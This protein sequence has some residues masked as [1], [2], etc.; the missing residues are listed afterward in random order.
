MTTLQTINASASPEV[1]INENTIA[2]SPAGLFG[3]KATTTA[4]LT[5]GYYGGIFPGTFSVIADGVLTLTNTATNYI[6]CDNAGTLFQNTSAFTAGRNRLYSVV[7]AGSVQTSY[8]DYRT[9]TGVNVPTLAGDNTFTGSNTFTGTVTNINVTNLSVTDSLIRL[10]AGNAANVLDIGTYGVYQPAATPLYAGLFRDATDGKYK[11]FD[12]LQ[13]EPT[14]TVNTVGTGYAAA[15]LVVG[16]LDTAA[17][18]A[19]GLITANAGISIPT[20]FNLTGAGTATVTGFASVSATALAGTLSTAAQPNVTSL[21][22]LTSLGISGTASY[23]ASG[24]D[25]VALSGLNTNNNTG[26]TTSTQLRLGITNS[27]G[28]SY[29]TIRAQEKANDDYPNI[30]FSAQ[31]ATTTTPTD[32][33]IIGFNGN[34][35]IGA[36]AGTGT[37]S[38]TA[39]AISGTTGAFSAQIS[40]TSSGNIFSRSGAS[41]AASYIYLA[42]TSGVSAVGIEGSA[43]GT[44]SI[45]TSPYDAVISGTNISFSATN[46]TGVQMRLASTGLAVTGTLSSTG[47]LSTTDATD[48]TSATAAA[49]KSAGGI[50]AVKS[51]WIGAALKVVGALTTNGG[52]QTF[53]ANDS[54]G[55]GYRLVVVPNI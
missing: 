45:G 40:S 3:R 5:W 55:S 12:S 25:L 2:L 31:N 54:G 11:L 14:T 8:T 48:A 24:T 20:G 13:A 23:S 43:G 7:C 10:A 46:G 47:I 1:Q 44:I 52:L 38:L 42:N 19:S 18:T 16:A 50:S 49:L 22:T 37:G 53:G 9:A 27:A 36:V 21:G 32:R 35:T 6:E 26:A 39:G 15:P 33:L 17:I 30:I 41:T 51:G 4:G 34:L 28:A 29:I